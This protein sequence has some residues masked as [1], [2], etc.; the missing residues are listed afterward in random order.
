MVSD[1]KIEGFIAKIRKDIKGKGYYLNP[2]EE[3][4]HTIID[5]LLTNQE[6]LG[7]LCCPCRAPADDK[8]KDRDI[9]CPCVY[10]YQDVS[11]HGSCYCA[12]Y[13]DEETFKGEKSVGPIPERR[14][15][16]PKKRDEMLEKGG[17]ADAG[18]F[19]TPIW[20]CTVCGY[21]C[22]M[23]QPPGKCPICGVPKERFEKFA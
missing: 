15:A 8:E 3:D 11:E 14:P 22:A 20:R 13:V 1:E 17:E 7:Y 6:N 18:T 19:K 12:L 9:I 10:M 2:N 4:L 21:L 23:D 5:G 16:D